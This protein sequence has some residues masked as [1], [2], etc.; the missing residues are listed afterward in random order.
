MP[1]LDLN[2]DLA[3]ELYIYL[4]AAISNRVGLDQ[5]YTY[6]S[7]AKD[8]WDWF[9]KSGVINSD[10]LVQ[11][12]LDKDSCVPNGAT[13]TYNQG[14]I[15]GGLVELFRATGELDWIDQAEKI[16]DAVTRPGSKL[17]DGDGILADGCDLDKSCK[18]LDDGT[19]FKGVFARN[20]K[21]L[22]AIRPS[23]QY[24]T[25]LQRNA[26]SIWQK[27]LHLDQGNCL[28]GVLWGGPYVDA[29]A[30]SQSSALD[31]LNAAAA[32]TAQ[33]RAFQAPKYS[34]NKDRGDAVKEAFDFAWNG[35]MK[36]AFP[37]DTLKP[38]DNTYTDDR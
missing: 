14:V 33:G 29:T 26:Q 2:A 13:F 19:Q 32:V 25:F 15:L 38:V 17:Q 28:N 36:Y 10:N 34:V 16:A 37:H 21:L 8:G 18:G 31:C 7:A 22:Y 9:K 23:D 6:L 30:S 3:T 27:D 11:D 35:Y 24:K 20:L 4:G 5:K 1:V 12:G